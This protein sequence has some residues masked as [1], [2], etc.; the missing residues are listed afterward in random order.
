VRL[1]E[2]SSEIVTLLLDDVLGN[3]AGSD[4]EVDSDSVEGFESVGE[5]CVRS[6]SARKWEDK[7]GEE[8]DDRSTSCTSSSSR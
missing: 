8:T 4:E 7:R 1:G 3:E 2:E 6:S 5:S